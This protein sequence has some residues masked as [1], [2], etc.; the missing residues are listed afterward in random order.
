MPFWNQSNF[1][2]KRQFKFKVVFDS[3]KAGVS[4][5]QY[6]LAQMAD[7][8][9]WTVTDGTKIDFLDKTFHYPGKVSWDPVT[10]TFIDGATGADN[11]ARAAY[12]YLSNA[13]WVSP[14]GMNA[15]VNSAEFA[16]IS[17]GGAVS[18]N[19]V[20]VQALKADGTIAESYVLY[21]SF[22]TNVDLDGFDYKGEGIL[23]AKF[24][25]RFDYAEIV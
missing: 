2:P 1:D 3:I 25:F 6:Y 15:G 16:T 18:G 8:P 24:K 14:A 20:T 19:D 7:R 23:T 22:V 17:K 5:T 13:G 10:I 11:M 21:N 12:R 9:K 4:P